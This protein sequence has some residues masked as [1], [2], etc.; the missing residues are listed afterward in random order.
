[1]HENMNR[2]LYACRADAQFR[3][4]YRYLADVACLRGTLAGTC[5]GSKY[6]T[7]RIKMAFV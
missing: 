1:M 5:C 4:W 6:L 3:K 2:I 7:I